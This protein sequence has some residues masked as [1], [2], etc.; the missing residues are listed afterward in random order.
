M[1]KIQFFMGALLMGAMMFTACDKKGSNDPVITPPSTDSTEVNEDLEEIP[2]LDAPGTGKVTIA[3]RVP[4][5]TCNGIEAVGQNVPEELTWTPGNSIKFEKVTD[6]E[7]WYKVTL[8]YAAD[9]A[10]KVIALPESGA[11]AW[12]TQWMGLDTEGVEQTTILQGAGEWVVENKVEYKLSGL[13][14]NEIIYI[15]VN[16]WQTAPCAPKNEAGVATFTMTAPALPEGAE[17]GI[18]GATFIVDGENVEWAI[19]NPIIMTFADGKYTATA[20]VGAACQYKYAYKLADGEWSWENMENSGNRQMALDLKPVDV[21]TEWVGAV[22][23][24]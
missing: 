10:V 18:V 22:A 17:V 8:T 1:K 16:Q 14:E 11:A 7:T 15:N 23:A 21:V 9:M 12:N 24:E 20:E 19:A 2:L 6:T 5:G 4:E 13:A 3:V